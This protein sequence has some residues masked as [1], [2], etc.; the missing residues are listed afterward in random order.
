MKRLL[1]AFA[2]V[3]VAVGPA[4]AQTEDALERALFNVTQGMGH[5]RLAAR[6][7]EPLLLREAEREIVGGLLDGLDACGDGRGRPEAARYARVYDAYERVQGL[8]KEI[9]YVLIVEPGPGLPAWSL[10]LRRN[11]WGLMQG[12]RRAAGTWRAELIA[13][14][15]R[16]RP[17]EAVG[18]VP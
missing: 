6:S 10:P 14:G 9:P 1:L 17:A 15:V 16:L 2:M 12:R 8:F 11:P 4:N 7:G 18:L 5:L 3:A 13:S